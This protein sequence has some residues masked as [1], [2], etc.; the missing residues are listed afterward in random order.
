M[1][2]RK[3]LNWLYIFFFSLSLDKADIILIIV[4][5]DFSLQD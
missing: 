4:A 5:K 1:C 2:E 3:I